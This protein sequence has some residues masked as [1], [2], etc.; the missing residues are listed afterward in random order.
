M[1]SLNRRCGWM[2]AVACLCVTA[3]TFA[4]DPS[5]GAPDKPAAHDNTLTQFSTIDALLAGQYDGIV[6]LGEVLKR[7]D[8]GLGTFH[9]LDGEL[10]ILDGQAWQVT[11]AGKVSRMNPDITTPLTVM[12]HFSPTHQ[13][14]INSIASLEAFEAVL[15]THITTS[16]AFLAIKVTGTFDQLRCRSVPAQDK[17]YP[18]LAEVIKTGQ[19][20]FD[21]A[22][23][24][25]TLVGIRCPA[26][27]KGLNVPGYHCS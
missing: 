22:A 2:L 12:T 19:V 18:P 14:T 5:T 1:L 8:F 11:A 20:I 21:H 3:I 7:G 13:L 23:T 6:T 24:K 27:S 17:P 9:R 10:I 15:D 16:N 26:F 25:G 4:A